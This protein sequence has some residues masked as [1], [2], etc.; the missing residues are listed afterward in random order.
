MA[1]KISIIQELAPQIYGR[2]WKGD[3][4]RHQKCTRRAID[5]WVKLKHVPPYSIIL[6]LKLY[7]QYGFTYD[8][9]TNEVMRWG[10][11]E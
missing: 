4:A 1:T 11:D 7:V 2:F 10:A 6:L 9:E 3:M 8:R 5:H